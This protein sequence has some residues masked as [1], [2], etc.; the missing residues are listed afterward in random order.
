MQYQIETVRNLL[1]NSKINIEGIQESLEQSRR[2]FKKKNPGRFFERILQESLKESQKNSGKSPRSN[3][4]KIL[5]M[6]LWR[7]L[8]KNQWCN[9]KRN[10]GRDACKNFKEI[11]KGIINEGTPVGIPGIILGKKI[12]KE[13]LTSWFMAI[14]VFSF[15][16]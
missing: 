16:R 2:Y 1:R 11:P 13:S 7:K 3:F 15:Y 14:S 5:G 10:S 9:P 6:N 12:R 8:E 4:W